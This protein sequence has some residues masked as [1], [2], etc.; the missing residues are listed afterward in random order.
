MRHMIVRGRLVIID[1]AG[2]SHAYG[3]DQKPSVTIKLHRRATNL[4]IAV[5]PA[6]AIPEA[7]MEGDLTIESGSLY[8]FLE[9]MGQNLAAAGPSRLMRLRE[10][11]GY[12][13]RRFMQYNPVALARRHAAH[14]Y[15]LTGELYELF[16]DPDRQYS[17]SYFMDPK[18]DLK[19]SQLHKKQH[20]AA[21]LLL[22]SGQRVLD[23]GSGWGG[24]A[25][26][27]AE[28]EHVDVTGLTLS[29]E[30][31]RVAERQARDRGLGE[32]VRFHLRDYRQEYGE[33]DRIVSVGMFEHVG[34]PYYDAYFRVVR[35]RLKPDGVAL[36]HT[37]G[38]A[39]GPGVTNPFIR[40][41]IFPGGYIPALSEVVPAIES[42]GLYI[43]DVEVLR[44]HYAE[45]LRAW[46]AQFLTNWDRAV[47]LHDER[48]CRMWEYYLAA[49]EVCFRYLGL[50]VFQ[51]QLAK[52]Q[53]AVPLTRDYI[54]DY[55]REERNVGT[56]LSKSFG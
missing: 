28:V 26:Y 19:T 23:I 43:T 4:R 53:D 48:F 46:R 11:V 22:K 25:F 10:R 34:V 50:V 9:F 15:N 36:V 1:S 18:E 41:Y 6:L 20:L 54:N 3:P 31:H 44:L 35:D 29:D 37:I 55:H 17:C 52:S 5:N 2:H 24:L 33:Y 56:D 21:K 27:L 38:R 47:N 42:V 40:K 49:S 13:S 12:L 30:Q 39:D 51:I 14:H 45:T 8:D 16:L 32:Q 7:Y